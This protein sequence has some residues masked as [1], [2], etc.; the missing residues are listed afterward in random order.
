M[1][2]ATKVP[3]SESEMGGTREGLPNSPHPGGPLLLTAA[4]LFLAQHL[5][6]LSALNLNSNLP[7]AFE[8][9][10][11]FPNSELLFPP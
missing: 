10:T 3:V 5:P 8:Q 1:G 9:G 7:C 11:S 4:M 6:T 2:D